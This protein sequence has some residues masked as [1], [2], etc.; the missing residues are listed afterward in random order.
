MFVYKMKY[1]EPYVYFS[2]DPAPHR[3]DP[4]KIN[5]SYQISAYTTRTK[6]HWN[7]IMTTKACLEKFVRNV[8]KESK[9]QNR[10]FKSAFW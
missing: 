2:T 3:K 4:I 6:L 10:T 9:L 5:L 1:D 7:K 8:L